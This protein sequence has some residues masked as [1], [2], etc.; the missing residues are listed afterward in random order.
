MVFGNGGSPESPKICTWKKE[1]GAPSEPTSMRH[2]ATL[3][4]IPYWNNSI[5]VEA[6]SENAMIRLYVDFLARCDSG[7]TCQLPLILAYTFLPRIS[8][9]SV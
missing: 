8:A 7:V 6:I 3:L 9:N 5:T 1:P 4:S 2:I